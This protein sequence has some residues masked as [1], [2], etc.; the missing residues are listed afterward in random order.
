[1]TA[2]LFLDDIRLCPDGYIL[3]RNY[4][5]CITLLE[6]G[7]FEEVSLDYSLGYGQKTGYDVL[8]WLDKHR[9]HLP[10][11]I[12]IHSTYPFG[13]H[14]MSNYIKAHFPEVELLPYREKMD[15]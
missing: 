4:D 7:I 15:C 11:K 10:K 2:K 1:M 3:V 12:N 5:D 8:V 9:E 13:V 6:N 14:Q